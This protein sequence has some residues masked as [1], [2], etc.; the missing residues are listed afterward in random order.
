MGI[1]ASASI[2]YL[3]ATIF[4]SLGLPVAASRFTAY[5]RAKQ[6]P[7]EAQQTAQKIL[8]VAL[9]ATL[10]LSCFL[11]LLSKNISHFML[12]TNNYSQTFQIVSITVFATILSTVSAGFMLGL[13]KFRQLAS[14]YVVSQIARFLFTILLIA[15]GLGVASIFWGLSLYGFLVILLTLPITLKNLLKPEK[16][17]KRNGPTVKAIFK[18]SLPMA[19]YALTTYM[20]TSVDSLLVLSLVGVEELGLYTVAS[21]ITSFT[22]IVLGSS[23]SDTLT[24]CMSDLHGKSGKEALTS[25]LKRLSRYASF[26]FIPMVMGLASLS[27]VI[28]KILGEQK[29]AHA[30][31]LITIN[32]ASLILYFIPILIVSALVA[33]GKTTSAMQIQLLTLA[34]CLSPCFI[35][36]I[37]LKT[38]GAAIS[39]A[40][41]FTVLL[42]TS[43]KIGS[44]A[45][46]LQLDR[47]AIAASIA[48]SALMGL[49]INTLAFHTSY[50]LALLPLYVTLGAAI[51]SLTLTATRT[52]KLEDIK[53]I[54]KTILGD[55]TLYN[56]ISG[57]I[58]NS[59]TLT[60]IVQKL[61]P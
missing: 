11:F 53:L 43:I 6:K 38:L 2:I 55:T 21:T 10:T 9:T 29:Y 19:I 56:R 15:T 54:S 49:T 12:G 44:K 35:L 59:K 26:I 48:A 13:Q 37:N 28:I 30:S 4:G 22:L 52:L 27:P 57:I 47:K 3:I 8:A 51:F 45:I 32:S 50:N 24:S 33:M 23:F 36:T 40:L 14:I 16:T 1:Y 58:S 17:E 41:L 39:K 31:I 46:P 25:E 5:L 20:F 7:H 60:K 61:F 42:I 18:F 34:I